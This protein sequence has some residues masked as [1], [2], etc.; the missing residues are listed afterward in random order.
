MVLASLSVAAGSMALTSASIDEGCFAS[1]STRAITAFT[2][3]FFSSS[4]RFSIGTI[5]SLMWCARRSSTALSFSLV[6]FVPEIRLSQVSGSA[7][8]LLQEDSM[9]A[10]DISPPTTNR[11]MRTPLTLCEAGRGFVDPHTFGVNVRSSGV[12]QG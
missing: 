3:G 5:A 6:I 12:L 7:G 10:N 1:P 11:R 4:R 9:R 8:S 2:S